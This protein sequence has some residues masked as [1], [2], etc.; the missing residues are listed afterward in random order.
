MSVPVVL[1]MSAYLF[2]RH[3]H[4]VTASLLKYEAGAV[5]AHGNDVD[6]WIEYALLKG[7]AFDPGP[8]SEPR[9]PGQD[10]VVVEPTLYAA[11]DS[12]VEPLDRLVVRDLTYEVEGVARQW[13]NPFSGRQL[14]CVIT[15]R[16]VDG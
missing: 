11:Y 14:G 6:S 5:D 7:C 13:E 15:L 4:G 16:K 12:P 2:P 10:R 9:L 1:G 8:T 3:K